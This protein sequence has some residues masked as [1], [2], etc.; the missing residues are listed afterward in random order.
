MNTCSRPKTRWLAV[1][2]L[3]L[4]LLLPGVGFAQLRAQVP[5][6]A[7]LGNPISPALRA[8]IRAARFACIRQRDVRGC[9]RMRVLYAER[10]RILR[11]HRAALRQ[12]RLLPP[13]RVIQG[14]PAAHGAHR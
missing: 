14:R 7:S 12:R 8:A 6:L 1:S 2:G 13:K 3:V 10:R 9:Q 4:A 5:P 11:A